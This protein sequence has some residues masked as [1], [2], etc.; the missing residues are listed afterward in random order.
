MNIVLFL[1]DTNSNSQSEVA[2]VAAMFGWHVVEVASSELAMVELPK[3]VAVGPLEILFH[4][5]HGF[6]AELASRFESEII[7][8]PVDWFRGLPERFVVPGMRLEWHQLETAPTEGRFVIVFPAIDR[9]EIWV[10]FV[11]AGQ[12]VE[13]RTSAGVV[14]GDLEG[15]VGEFLKAA[16]PSCPAPFAILGARLADGR[17]VILGLR[18]ICV[19]PLS[20]TR[21]ER[22]LPLLRGGFRMRQAITPAEKG[23][24]LEL[25][26]GWLF[27]RSRTVPGSGEDR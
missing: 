23:W 14:S 19:A 11:N 25:R 3:A 27:L 10:V 22:T 21:L 5:T 1:E 26:H 18:P 2:A 4:G 7:G 24:C 16:Y 13:A 6:V 17:N 20:G 12:L 15:F 9:R 8:P